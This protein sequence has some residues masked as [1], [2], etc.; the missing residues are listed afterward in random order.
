MIY[1]EI[2]SLYLYICHQTLEKNYLIEIMKKFYYKKMF[3]ILVINQTISQ[4]ELVNWCYD[5]ELYCTK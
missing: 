1:I 2:S 5:I 4:S 3:L